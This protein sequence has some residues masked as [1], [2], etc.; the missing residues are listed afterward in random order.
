MLL[1]Y[2]ILV[3]TLMTDDL[4][5][6]NTSIYNSFRDVLCIYINGVL[7]FYYSTLVWTCENFMDIYKAHL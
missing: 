6:D 2:F 1:Y 3:G 4:V 5:R 7:S